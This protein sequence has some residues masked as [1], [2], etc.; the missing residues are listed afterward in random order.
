MI[1]FLVFDF[2]LVLRGH[3]FFFIPATTANDL[4]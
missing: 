1:Y 4:C 3:S 2:L